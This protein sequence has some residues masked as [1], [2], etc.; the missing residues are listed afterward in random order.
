MPKIKYYDY[1]SGEWKFANSPYLNGYTKAETNQ[2]ITERQGELLLKE[3]LE[4]YIDSTNGSDSTGS[5]TFSSPFATI[6]Y[7]LSIVP[8]NLNGHTLSIECIG[9]LVTSNTIEIFD[10]FGGEII[11]HANT[12]TS[13]ADYV[14]DIN[15]DIFVKIY[16]NVLQINSTT[17]SSGGNAVRGINVYAGTVMI[18]TAMSIARNGEGG[19]ALWAENGGRIVLG[20]TGAADEVEISGHFQIA[21][22]SSTAS[23]IATASSR[24]I[25]IDEG[26]NTGICVTGAGIFFGLTTNLASTARTINTGLIYENN[27]LYSKMDASSITSGTLP[28]ARGGT[29]VT[30]I[31]SGN[32]LIGNGTG[33]ITSRAITNLTAKGAVTGSTNLATANTV[34]YHA[35]NRLNRTTAVNAA[36]TAYTTYMARAIA[37]NTTDLTAGTSTLTN[38]CIYLVYE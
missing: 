30:S 24:R 3:D 6:Q 13:T 20:W 18:Y 37:A 10:F 4:Y 32:A 15:S 12:I 7:A 21:V 2:I 27:V 9:A 35:Q 31:T 36:D 22:Q 34:L 16:S 17:D 29:G 11:L 19:V 33:A 1:T 25:S 28:V 38:G 26:V 5:G 23:F 14:F 8:K